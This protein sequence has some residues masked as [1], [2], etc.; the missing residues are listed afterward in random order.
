MNSLKSWL[1][2]GCAALALAMPVRAASLVFFDASGN[3]SLDPA[4]PQSTSGLAQLPLIAIYDSLV[5]Q[6]DA[7]NLLPR[8]ATSWNYNQDLTEFTMR[9]RQ[10][11]TFHDGTKFNAAAVATNLERGKSL[12]MRAGTTILDTVNRI[13]SIEILTEDTIRLHLNEPN[14]RCHTC[15]RRKAGLSRRRRAASAKAC[16]S[17]GQT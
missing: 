13:K 11:V 5:G 2:A 14:A 9:L 8:L 1:L 17:A 15:W 16:G 10:G 12:G 7:G 6:D 3:Q 4:E